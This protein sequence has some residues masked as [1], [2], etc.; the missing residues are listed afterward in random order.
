MPEHPAGKRRLLAFDA[1]N[2]SVKAAALIGGRWQRLMRVPT[3]PADGLVDRM[4]EAF[5]PA[6]ARSLRPGRCV[7]SSV[8]PAADDAVTAYWRSAGG[9]EAEFFGRTLPV[10]MPTKVR[11]PEKVGTD[12]LLITL[13]AKT[14][15]GAPCIVVSAGTAIT[16]DLVDANG[17]LAGGAIAP[18]FHVAALALHE[19]TAFLPLVE[20]GKPQP[21]L[22]PDTEDAVRSGVYWSCA[23]GVLALVDRFRSLPGA[24]GAPLVCT[25][26]DAPLLL[27]ALPEGEACCEPDLIFRGMAAALG[28]PV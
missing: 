26:T 1:G 19:H 17:A 16:V 22:G 4:A 27:P 2:T 11:E 28:M 5:P 18:G 9:R 20:L 14:F 8:C 24:A 23:G 10:P 3:K 15:R 13:A 12:R 21:F 7:V 25:G 6:K